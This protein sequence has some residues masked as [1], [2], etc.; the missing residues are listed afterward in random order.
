MWG[1]PEAGRRKLEAHRFIPTHVGNTVGDPPTWAW[2]P[3]HPHACGEHCSPGPKPLTSNGSSPRMWGTQHDLPRIAVGDRFIPTH[4]GNTVS[5]FHLIAARAVHPHACG[6]HLTIPANSVPRSGSSP[7]KWGTPLVHGKKS[8]L[9]RVIPAQGGNTCRRGASHCYPAV[10]PHAC[11]EHRTEEIT[12]RVE[13]GSS[14]RMWG[15]LRIDLLRIEL[16]RFIPTH[17]GNTSVGIEHC[18][19]WAVHPHACGEHLKAVAWVDKVDGSSPRMWGTLLSP[20]CRVSPGRFIPTHVGNTL[21]V[22]NCF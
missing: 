10:H 16:R 18:D 3:V 7:R 4:V 20:I 17:V 1:T 13:D 2:R 6:E 11:G 12:Q 19:I 22:Q 14:P 15:T 9:R 5:Q 8:A 21:T